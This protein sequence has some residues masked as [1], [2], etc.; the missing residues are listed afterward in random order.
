MYNKIIKEKGAIALLAAICLPILLQISA[1]VIDIA[2]YNVVKQELQNAADASAL[3]GANNYFD[4]AQVGTPNLTKAITAAKNAAK[5]N[6]VTGVNLTD[7]EIVVTGQYYDFTDKKIYSTQ[8]VSNSRSLALQVVT[9][10]S[11]VLSFLSGLIGSGAFSNQATS[12]AYIYSPGKIDEGVAPV[13]FVFQDCVFNPSINRSYPNIT[14]KFDSD[15]NENPC[16]GVRWGHNREE[17]DDNELYRIS[18]GDDKQHQM[19]I[20]DDVVKGVVKIVKSP[21]LDDNLFNA[22]G[23]KKNQKVICPTAN[24][25]TKGTSQKVTGFNCAVITY[26]DREEKKVRFNLTDGCATSDLGGSGPNYGV[27]KPAKLVQ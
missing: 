23:L 3:R 18:K 2:N 22:I 17:D 9:K 10:K 11:N 7:A 27:Y 6:M 16:P 13:P 20:S 24:K 19:E 8:S 1:F 5:A 26:I 25:I 4:P 12:I 15:D 14:V 21:R